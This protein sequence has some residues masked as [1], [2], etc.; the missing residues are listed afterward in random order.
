MEFVF[1]ILFE[2]ERKEVRRIGSGLFY[3]HDDYN[4]SFDN[5][6]WRMSEEHGRPE[7]IT[8]HMVMKE[9]APPHLQLVMKNTEEILKR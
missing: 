5:L 4:L 2:T 3:P 9:E 1:E 8:I 7:K 6:L